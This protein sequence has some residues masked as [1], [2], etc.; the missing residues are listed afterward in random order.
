MTHTSLFPALIALLSAVAFIIG[1]FF[2]GLD[3]VLFTPALLCVLLMAALMLAGGLRRGWDFPAAVSTGFL[4]LFWLWMTWALAWSSV[5]QVSTV[6]T[7]LIGSIPLLVFATIQHSRAVELVRAQTV[8]ITGVMVIVALWALTQFF[9]LHDLAGSRIHHPMLNTNN[10]AVLL[11]MAMFP[12]MLWFHRAPGWK[13]VFPGACLVLLVMAMMTTQSRGGLL[14]LVCGVGV[15]GIFCFPLIRQQARRFIWLFA[16]I[17]CGVTVLFSMIDMREEAIRFMGGGNAMASV[18]ERFLLLGSGLRMMM[19][20]PFPGIGLGAFY[21]AFPPYRHA[22]D[23][24]DGYFL[25]VDPIQFGIEMSPVA[26]VLFYAFCTALLLRTVFAVRAAQDMHAR[27]A[28]L[29][30]FASLLALLVN[31][32][33]NFDLYMLP[34]LMAAA[35]MIGA[36]F[37]ATEQVLGPARMRMTLKNHAHMAF[38]IPVFILAFLLAPIWL[39]RAGVGVQEANLASAAISKGDIHAAQ[40]HIDR[41]MK[42]GV[43]SYYRVY[44]LDS[45]W[46]VHMLRTQFFALTAMERAV[47]FNTALQSS[48]MALRYNPYYVHSLN[49]KALLYVLG[50]PRLATDGL[51]RAQTILQQSL[52]I[53][54]L[55]FDA[56]MGLAKVMVMQN[57]KEQAIQVLEDGFYWNAMRRYAPVPYRQ[58]LIQ[59]KKDTGQDQDVAALNQDMANY[60]KMAQYRA[61]RRR[62]IDQWVAEKLRAL[63]Q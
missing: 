49:Q 17:L 3:Q 57:R 39:V 21:L 43:P 26:T 12:M 56:R 32:H 44:H 37:L 47:L 52:T 15:C 22:N 27:T 53:D 40:T 59:L 6:F 9:F 38:L 34:A 20:H 33:V 41:A 54:P 46:R 60:I 2:R 7:L 31:I 61:K 55:S 45:M 29:L 4:A 11:V 58:L 16:A 63:L 35:L 23:L 14:G 1:I 51:E 28:I 50:Y 25:H 42:Y 13:S 30:P 36:W 62:G 19:D 48:D 8:A 24:S 10:L 5:P 18:N